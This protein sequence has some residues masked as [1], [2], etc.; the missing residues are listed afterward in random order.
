MTFSGFSPAAIEWL[1]DLVEHNSRDWFDANRKT[2]EREVLDVSKRFV[3][4]MG[5]ALTDRIDNHIVAE[6][7]V[8]GSI[9][10]INRDTRFSADKTPYKDHLH[11]RFWL[12]G[13]RG[14]KK[15][16]RPAYQMRVTSSDAGF[17]AGVFGFADKGHLAAYQTAVDDDTRGEELVGLLAAAEKVGLGAGG[18]GYKRVPK[19]Y[20]ADHPRGD[21]LRHK[22]LFVSR[23][24]PLTKAVDSAKFVDWC[25]DQFEPMSPV[26]EWVTAVV[27]A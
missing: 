5:D 20:P 11:Y 22:G 6:A 26:V 25:V 4:A 9:A 24:R 8:N 16:A 13:G 1:S 10:P 21:L 17:M 18:E 3:E 27:D 15:T 19:P 7:K 14:D 23:Q 2:Y 12:E